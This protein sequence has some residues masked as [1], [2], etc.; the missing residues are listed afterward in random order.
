MSE[1]I[2]EKCTCN[3]KTY[4]HEGTCPF[5]KY[6][7]YPEVKQVPKGLREQALSSI[8]ELRHVVC[9]YRSLV[10]D[11]GAYFRRDKALEK[12]TKAIANAD[13]AIEALEKGQP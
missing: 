6:E 11:R 9:Y 10:L 5:Y 7:C 1:P 3:P 12:T 4:V 2:Q 13:K 8:E